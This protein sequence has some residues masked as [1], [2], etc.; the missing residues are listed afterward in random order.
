[1]TRKM[2]KVLQAR[3]EKWKGKYHELSNVELDIFYEGE[4]T[5]AMKFT[6]CTVVIGRRAVSVTEAG[7]PEGV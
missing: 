3:V 1:M 7:S 4:R 5:W 2:R 6:Y